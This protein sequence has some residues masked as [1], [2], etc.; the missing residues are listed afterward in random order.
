M[1]TINQVGIGLSG[2]NGT[3]TFAGSTNAILTTP[4]IDAATATTVTFNPTTG[5]LVGTTTNDNA[6][7]GI[8]GEFISSVIPSA[9]GL[10]PT[11]GSPINIT[12]ISL[13]AGDWDV[14]GNVANSAPTT[15]TTV[16]GWVSLVSATLANQNSRTSYRVMAGNTIRACG[17]NTN[18]LRVSISTTTTVFLSCQNNF[19][20]SMTVFGGIYARRAR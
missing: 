11:S 16:I 8:V 15:G 2:S 6:S 3:G 14:I 9:S 18:Y 13:T 19:T 5:G 10:T 12:S 17:I 1:A 4:N 20:G 7:A